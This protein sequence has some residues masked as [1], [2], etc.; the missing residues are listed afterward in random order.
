VPEA[1]PGTAEYAARGEI[2]VTGR[3]TTVLKRI[4]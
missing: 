1:A 4:A 2:N 3:S